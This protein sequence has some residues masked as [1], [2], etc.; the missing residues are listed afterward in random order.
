MLLLSVRALIQTKMALWPL[1][2]LRTCQDA[3]VLSAL[4]LLL[5]AIAVSSGS[6]GSSSHVCPVKC[7]CLGTLV[8]CSKKGLKEVPKDLPVWTEIL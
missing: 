2:N 4:L 1:I 7:V 3:K 8:D 5:S 6:T